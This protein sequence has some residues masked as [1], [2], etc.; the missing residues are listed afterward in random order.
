MH[1]YPVAISG[2][3][4]TIIS[5]V[6]FSGSN[7]ALEIAVSAGKI[8]EIR[9][10]DAA[11]EWV[12]L[13]PL[14]DKHVH[15]NRAF[16]L[17]GVK[18]D[19]LEH[20]IALT[21]ELFS[22]FGAGQYGLHAR[23]LFQRAFS[24]GTTGIRTHADIDCAIRFAAVQGTLDAAA[25]M[26]AK[27]NIEVVAFATQRLDPSTA[28][29]RSLIK[30]AL[31]RGANLI[32][33]TPALYAE[34]RRSIDSVIELAI[35]RDAALDLHQDEHL[36]PGQASVDYLADAV[37]GN[38]LQ[39]RLTLSHGCVL[40]MLEP[41]ARN[42]IIEKLLRAQIE[43]V[44]LPLTNLYLQDRG[45]GTPRQR[46]LTCVHEMLDAGIELRFASDNVRDAFYPYG[47]ADLLDTLYAGMLGAQL[48]SSAALVKSICD[49]RVNL[50]VGEPADLVLIQGAD[51]DR[52][53]SR[54]PAERIIIRDGSPVE[55][56]STG[57]PE[58]D[59]D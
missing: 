33:A 42:K 58:A 37:I 25:H 9:E 50:S 7:Q 19:S 21:L 12:C 29:G 45:A 16:T 17:A 6:A 40:S 13:P 47:D 27:M 26:A 49:G 39:G 5:N 14:V 55:I 32:G 35:E 59:S 34:P 3:N 38:G 30:E 52:I 10:L 54:R 44:A 8:A 51:F 53:L 22:G 1:A 4:G 24:H 56:H 11:V 2:D 20:A 48:D 15:A 28:D 41:A 18:P 46:G 57:F 31:S 36:S 43:V 23:K